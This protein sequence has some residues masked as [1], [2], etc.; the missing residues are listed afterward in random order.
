MALELKCSA[1]QH[2]W[3]WQ[4]FIGEWNGVSIMYEAEWSDAAKL[5]LYTGG[6]LT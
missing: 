2:R 6:G 4:R 1:I 3:W 5:R